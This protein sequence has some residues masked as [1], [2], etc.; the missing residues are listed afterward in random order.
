MKKPSIRKTIDIIQLVMLILGNLIDI[1][2][3]LKNEE[4]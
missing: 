3:E 4:A 2:K 1:V